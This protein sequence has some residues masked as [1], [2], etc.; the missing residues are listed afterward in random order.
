MI[1]FFLQGFLSRLAFNLQRVTLLLGDMDSA[2][3]RAMLGDQS[4]VPLKALFKLTEAGRG[5]LQLEPGL[6]PA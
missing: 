4:S 5:A 6:T 3:S 2:E 1:N